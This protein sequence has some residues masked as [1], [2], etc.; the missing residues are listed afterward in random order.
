MLLSAV[1]ILAIISAPVALGNSIADTTKLLGACADFSLVAGTAITFDG[2]LTA[3]A[4]GDIGVSPGISVTGVFSSMR[5]PQINTEKSIACNND[6]K[7]AY[8]TAVALD[9]LSSNIFAELEGRTLFSGVYCSTTEMKF[10]ASMVTLDG[11][12]EANPIWVFNV[13]TAL[14]TATLTHFNLINGAVENNVIWAIGTAATFGYNSR[15]VGNV[16]A[17]TALTFATESRLNGR[18]LALTGISFASGSTITLPSTAVI[19]PVPTSSPV[20]RVRQL[21]IIT[22]IEHPV[23]VPLELKQCK[24]FAVLAGTSLNFDGVLT[25]VNNG[26]AGSSPGFVVGANKQLVSGSDEIN[27]DLA[28]ACAANAQTLYQTA[29]R[30]ECWANHT[31]QT[32]DLAGVYLTPGVYCS[33]TGTLTFSAA[34]VTLDALNK[35][36]AQWVFQA[37]STLSTAT[38]T[39]FKLINGA[40]A[41]NVFWALGTSASIGYS[42]NFVGTILAQ[43]AI[44]FGTSA[45]IVGRGIA[46]TA[47]TFSSGGVIAIP[48]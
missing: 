30:A 41:K 7:N 16:L 24:N 12:N 43:A 37:S 19:T 32:S 28:K 27:T 4:T 45:N 3:V 38:A 35:T 8:K 17:Q 39:S 36:D 46:Q 48:K 21:A 40:Q 22:P 44:T 31:L 13:G 6:M 18:G 1:T 15:F 23:K 34:T 14:T 25:V 33:A 2:T 29:S 10:S 26:S 42:S 20:A 11:R 9:C 5:A 47:I